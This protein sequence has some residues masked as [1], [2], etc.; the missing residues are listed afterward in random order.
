MLNQKSP[1]LTV[2]GEIMEREKKRKAPEPATYKPEMK[3]V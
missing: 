2:A 3:L 1:R